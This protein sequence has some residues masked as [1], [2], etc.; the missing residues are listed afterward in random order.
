MRERAQCLFERQPRIVNCSWLRGQELNVVNVLRGPAFCTQLVTTIPKQNVEPL[1]KRPRRVKPADRLES[2]N[3]SFLNR[4]LG[5][6]TIEQNSD[7]MT[8]RAFLI[9]LDKMPKS[10]P[11]TLLTTFN[12]LGIIHRRLT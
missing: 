2:I 3:K 11:V 1:V 12:R 6:I 4:V 8:D 10:F 5:I 9:T 7:S